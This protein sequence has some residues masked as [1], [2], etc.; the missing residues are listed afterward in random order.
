LQDL[1][2]QTIQGAWRLKVSDR[3][4]REVGKLNRWA[5]KFTRE[6]EDEIPISNANLDTAAERQF[7][8]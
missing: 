8:S 2:G 6:P 1:H 4:A 3:V 7:R 5:L